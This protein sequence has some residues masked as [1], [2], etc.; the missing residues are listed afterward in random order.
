[1]LIVDT[2]P[3]ILSTEGSNKLLYLGITKLSSWKHLPS[4]IYASLTNIGVYIYT[5]LLLL[6]H[7]LPIWLVPQPHRPYD[8]IY[9]SLPPIGTFSEISSTKSI[10][11]PLTIAF[12]VWRPNPQWKRKSP[13]PPDFHVCVLDGRDRFPSLAQL[14][15]SLQLCRTKIPPWKEGWKSSF[16]SCGKGCFE[17]YDTR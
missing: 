2:P 7:S 9:A 4:E 8:A 1:M 12:E 5:F 16:S 13:G 17:L 14:E 11:D 6:L 3:P 15:T 10:E